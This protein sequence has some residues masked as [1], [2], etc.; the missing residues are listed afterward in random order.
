[1]PAVGA[2]VLL[3]GLCVP[4]QGAGPKLLYVAASA[5]ASRGLFDGVLNVAWAR[6]GGRP[7]VVG[8]EGAP[9]L[10][11]L[12][13]A[14]R[15]FPVVFVDASA[16]PGLDEARARILAEYAAGGGNLILEGLSV[17]ERLRGIAPLG[18]AGGAVAAGPVSAPNAGHPALLG[19]GYALW[20]PPRASAQLSNG[21]QAI[22]TA[23]GGKVPLAA[24][25]Q[26][27]RGKVVAL[28][29]DHDPDTFCPRERLGYGS[30]L[31]LLSLLMARAGD[32]EVL[33]ESLRAA[34][35]LFIYGAFPVG[36]AKYRFG[37]NGGSALKAYDEAERWSSGMFV[38]PSA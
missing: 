37:L 9:D 16:A 34:Q 26:Q 31:R 20:S 6:A 32:E 24:V 4:A 23:A 5:D 17:A 35:R 33:A 29:Y 10:T 22:L 27:G 25:R 30:L 2:V 19:L 28:A 38:R 7:Y 12:G 21:G 8:A 1:M 11:E 3:L 18:P 15:R 13:Q 14:L 36:Y